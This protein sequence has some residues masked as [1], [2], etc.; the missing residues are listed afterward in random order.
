MAKP[1]TRKVRFYRADF[2][3]VS[4]GSTTLLRDPSVVFAQISALPF[5]GNGISRSLPA[6]DGDDFLM[7]VDSLGEVVRGRIGRARRAL[8]P[9]VEENG[10]LGPVPVPPRAGLFEATHFVLFARSGIVGIVPEG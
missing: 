8:L 1:I 3:G 10:N 6:G 7:F 2:H 9:D 5:G 4:N